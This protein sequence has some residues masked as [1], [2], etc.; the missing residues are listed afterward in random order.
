[1]ATEPAHPPAAHPPA[2]GGGKGLN[3][4]KIVGISILVVVLVMLNVLGMF[5]GQLANFLQ[6]VRFNGAV[7]LALGALWYLTKK[8]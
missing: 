7:F 8:S 2:P 4:G 6:V 1:M 5:T 3:L